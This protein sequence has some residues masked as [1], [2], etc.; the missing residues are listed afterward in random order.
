MRYVLN[1]AN[2]EGGHKM[3]EVIYVELYY[4]SKQLLTLTLTLTLLHLK[5]A[6]I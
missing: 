4:T 2:K 6:C 1:F 3:K 5:A